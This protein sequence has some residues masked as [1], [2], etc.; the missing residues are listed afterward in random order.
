MKVLAVGAWQPRSEG[1]LRARVSIDLTW[2]EETLS[3]AAASGCAAVFVGVETF[4]AENLLYPDGPHTV[5]R[6]ARP[7]L[8]AWERASLSRT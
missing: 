3:P 6:G 7:S 5:L 4:S 8:G 1:D 2:D